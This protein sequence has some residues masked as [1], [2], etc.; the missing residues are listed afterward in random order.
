VIREIV[1]VIGLFLL[2]YGLFLISPAYAFI[3]DGAILVL[4]GLFGIKDGPT[5]IF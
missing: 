3:V 4:L 2:G 1:C 5:K